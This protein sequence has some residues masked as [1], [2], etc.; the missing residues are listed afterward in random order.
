[1][2]AALKKSCL[3][4]ALATLG[5]AGI[6]AQDGGEIIVSGHPEYPPMMWREGDEIIGAATDYASR[7]FADLKI[8]HRVQKVK[9]LGAWDKVLEDVKN[10]KIDMV[11]AAY[12]N[13]ERRQ[14][15]EFTDPIAED[16][17]SVFTL[18]EADISIARLEDLKGRKG[19][20]GAGESFGESFDSLARDELDLERIPLKDAFAKLESKKVDYV[21]AGKFQ[22]T[23]VARQNRLYHK[24]EIQPYMASVQLFHIGIS[25]KS[26]LVK[27][28]PEI[29]KK[30]ERYEVDNLM[31]LYLYRAQMRWESI[32]L[33]GY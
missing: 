3:S 29:N 9:Y 11:V 22:G 8:Q 5:L 32:V 19:A 25:K 20:A 16:P 14:W 7:L 15:M 12:K 18:K 6:F 2:N 1:M 27:M 24:I 17:V 33:E 26:P 28:I 4:L 21:V 31:D 13:D 30:I 23:F 10:G